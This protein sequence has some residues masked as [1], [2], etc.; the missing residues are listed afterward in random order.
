MSSVLEQVL[1][2]LVDIMKNAIVL[3]VGLIAIGIIG[4]CVLQ[5]IA[6]VY[7]RLHPEKLIESPD[8]Q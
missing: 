1:A 3:A 4:V 7:Y 8:S 2:A 6:V 5:I